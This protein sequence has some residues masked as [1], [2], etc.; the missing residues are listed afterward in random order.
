VGFHLPLEGGALGEPAKGGGGEVNP[1]AK[2]GRR[3]RIRGQCF[4]W[5]SPGQFSKGGKG[6][7]FFGLE[8][9]EGWVR[10]LSSLKPGY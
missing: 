9:Y 2:D 7:G 5:A 6:G 10:V 1:C 3:K 4:E 8:N